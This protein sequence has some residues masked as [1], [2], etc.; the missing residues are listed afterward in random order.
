MS[1]RHVLLVTML[2][3]A[4]ASVALGSTFGGR[5]H[6]LL[7]WTNAR[8]ATSSRFELAYPR[9]WYATSQDGR[10]L[11]VSSFPVSRKWLDAERRSLP[12]K[13]IFIGVFTYGRLPHRYGA[14]FPA[15]PAHLELDPK[16]FGFYECGLRLEGYVLRFRERGFAVQVAVALAPDADPQAAL[17]VLNRLRVS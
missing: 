8:I 10:D 12:S 11:V 9:G 1:V 14:T 16:T 4:G 15:R 3:L 2:T 5:D 17:A 7:D 13:G 6:L